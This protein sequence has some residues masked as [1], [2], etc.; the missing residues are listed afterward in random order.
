[1][2]LGVLGAGAVGPDSGLGSVVPVAARFGA[3]VGPVA[4]AETAS[5][6]GLLAQAPTVDAKPMLPASQSSWRRLTNSER[7]S[8][9]AGAGAS[10]ALTIRTQ[11]SLEGR[12][13]DLVVN[14]CR[15]M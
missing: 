5:T 14:Q 2:T 3:G 12:S 8:G 10:M 9:W 13:A 6:R 11:S 1:V 15:T 4:D 7:S